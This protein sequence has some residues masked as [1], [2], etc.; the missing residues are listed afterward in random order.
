MSDAMTGVTEIALVSATIIESM[1]QQYLQQ[2]MIITPTLQPIQA[3]K[4]SL[5]VSIPKLAGFTVNDKAEGVAVDAQATIWGADS[6]SLNKHKVI[7]V[8]VEKIADLQSQPNLMAAYAERMGLDLANAID[9]FVISELVQASA[10]A[11]DHRVAFAGSTMAATDVVNA[12]TLLDVQNVPKTDRFLAVNP[13]D[14]KALLLIDN[15]VRYDA[16]GSS[17]ALINGAIGKVYG[18][19]V[20]ASNNISASSAIAYHKSACAVAIQASPSYQEQ[21]QLEYLATRASLDVV[22]GAKLLDG[23][24]RCVKI[25]SAS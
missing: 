13:V 7:Q 17:A 9:I 20:I 23:G 12:A 6:L 14:H 25:G 5:A 21:A 4:G 11:P 1:V 15:F 18:F 3:P 2:A 16:Y 24:K 19:E 10:S 22:F 8:L